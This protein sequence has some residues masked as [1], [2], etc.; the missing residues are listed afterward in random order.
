[1]QVDLKELFGRK[2][3]PD[4]K[5]IIDA[6]YK[7]NTPSKKLEESVAI[8]CMVLDFVANAKN[9]DPKFKKNVR[10]FASKFD[11]DLNSSLKKID[12]KAKDV[13]TID[14]INFTQEDMTINDRIAYLS[15]TIVLL[16]TFGKEQA[17]EQKKLVT[18]LEKFHDEMNKMFKEG[19][20]KN[21]LEGFKDVLA[22]GGEV[23]KAIAGVL[24]D[25]VK[26]VLMFTLKVLKTLWS[27]I[28][29]VLNY[30]NQLFQRLGIQNLPVV[31]S[32]VGVVA[33]AAGVGTVAATCVVVCEGIFIAQQVFAAS[34]IADTAA[35]FG[36]M[37]SAFTGSDFEQA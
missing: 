27:F 14:L 7:E 2:T 28:S 16:G 36:D 25:L 9:V 37:V 35:S 10:R 33:M 24:W 19:T 23:L 31:L 15:A 3:D 34:E 8:L 5:K 22:K 4:M 18:Q 20:G 17:A 30:F 12:K 13:K 32:V 29:P 21:L 26:P 11:S 1:M 6:L